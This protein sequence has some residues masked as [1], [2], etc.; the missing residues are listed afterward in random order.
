MIKKVLIFVQTEYHLMIAVNQILKLY[1]NKEVYNVKLVIQNSGSSPR[2]KQELDFSEFTYCEVEYW[3]D[4]LEVSKPL[5][6]NVKEKIMT[7]LRNP[8]ETFIFFQEQ[9]PLMVIL[10]NHFSMGTT[11]IHLYQDGLKPYNHL[12]FHSIGLIK[13]DFNQNLWLKRNGFLVRNWLSPIWSKK[14][15]F[16]KGI[17]KVLARCEDSVKVLLKRKKLH[18]DLLKKV[19][20][21]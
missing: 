6:S 4:E 8:P 12:K 14:Y 16:L 20:L 18:S 7:L 9:D 5:N 15:A 19:K 1:N 11:E 13:I 17:S 21:Q 2:L 3:K 10:V